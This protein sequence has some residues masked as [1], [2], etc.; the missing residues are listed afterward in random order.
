LVD[1]TIEFYVFVTDAEAFKS[2]NTLRRKYGENP[3]KLED[4]NQIKG[5][6][7]MLELIPRGEGELEVLVVK[8]YEEIKTGQ[9]AIVRVDLFNTGTLPVQEVKTVMTLPYEWEAEIRPPLIQEI[10]PGE[11]E[12]IHITII[13]PKELGVGEYDLYV[14]AVG[15]VGNEK[16]ESEEKNITIRVTAR[17]NILGNTVLIGGLILLVVGIAVVSIKVSRR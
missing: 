10:E 2:I 1:R 12:P 5:N 14:E 13:P 11:K 9:E 7:V 8:T 16:E 15:L 6:K 17:A 3:F 4:I